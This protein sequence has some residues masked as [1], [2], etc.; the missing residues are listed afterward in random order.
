MNQLINYFIYRVFQLTGYEPQDLIEKTLYQHI[1]LQDL[2]S[3]KLAHQTCMYMFYYFSIT[4]L[5]VNVQNVF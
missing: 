2:P 5:N 1:H 3:I 4:F